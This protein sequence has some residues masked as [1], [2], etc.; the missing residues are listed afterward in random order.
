MLPMTIR[1]IRITFMLLSASNLPL[2]VSWIMQKRYR[3]VDST[4]AVLQSIRSGRNGLQLL[5]IAEFINTKHYTIIIAFM[6]LP[7]SN[8]PLQVS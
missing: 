2:Q 7:V 5:R 4:S 8:L 3:R 1:R 6:L